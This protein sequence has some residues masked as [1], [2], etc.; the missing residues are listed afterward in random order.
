MRQAIEEHFILDVLENYT[1]FKPYWK[2]PKTTEDDPRY[3]KSK[4]SCLLKSFVDLHEHAIGQKVEIMLE[5]FH[6]QV[7]ASRSGAGPRP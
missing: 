7:A 4:A 3:E 6:D 5:H 1:T 2:L